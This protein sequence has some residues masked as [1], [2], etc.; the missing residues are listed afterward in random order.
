MVPNNPVNV[1]TTIVIFIHITT[2]TATRANAYFEPV[3]V[4]EGWEVGE[5]TL[6]RN[7]N[8]S[9]LMELILFHSA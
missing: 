2:T 8:S 6:F 1:W 9:L 5:T 7:V 3:H 4:S